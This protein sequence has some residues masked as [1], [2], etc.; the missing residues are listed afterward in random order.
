MRP[1]ASREER[2]EQGEGEESGGGHVR[3]RTLAGSP[4]PRPAR[5][6]LNPFACAGRSVSVR[7]M[8]RARATPAQRRSD[9]APLALVVAGWALARRAPGPPAAR[10]RHA[11][12][13]AGRGRR[14][15]QPCGPA[16]RAHRA[17]PS[18]RAPA[19]A[20]RA[21]AP[22]SSAPG[23]GSR[24][25]LPDG[26]AR[27]A[28]AAARRAPPHLPPPPVVAGAAAGAVSPGDVP[29]VAHFASTV[30]P[31]ACW[32]HMPRSVRVSCT[33]ILLLTGALAR[34]QRDSSAAPPARPRSSSD[35]G[36][37]T[38]PAGAD[39]GTGPPD[40]GKPAAPAASGRRERERPARR[41]R[42]PWRRPPPRRRPR[43]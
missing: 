31:P 33:L 14:L 41:S 17:C 38:P 28:L 16:A 21:R 26:D 25:P 19:C 8:A 11:V 37:L 35:R 40:A 43:R 24:S 22:S 2:A 13:P 18:R 7:A 6:R 9:A 1:G 32:G 5:F 34:A 39:P 36:R 3:G 10:P 20:R 4:Y 42:Q 15:G 29:P 23:G 12:P 27:G 30:V